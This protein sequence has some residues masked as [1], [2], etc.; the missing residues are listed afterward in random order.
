MYTGLGT[1]VFYVR[2]GQSEN[3]FLSKFRT[4]FTNKLLERNMPIGILAVIPT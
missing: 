4:D 3:A 2:L 1:K